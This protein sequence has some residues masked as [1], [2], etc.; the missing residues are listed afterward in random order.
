MACIWGHCQ[1]ARRSWLPFGNHPLPGDMNLIL[2]FPGAIPFSCPCAVILL[3]TE[4]GKGESMGVGGG[5]ERKRGRWKT[6]RLRGR[7]ALSTQISQ[8]QGS[9]WELGDQGMAHL[10]SV[11]PPVSSFKLH[12]PISKC[13][14]HS[15]EWKAFGLLRVLSWVSSLSPLLL[16][17]VCSCGRRRPERRVARFYS[18]AHW[19]GRQQQ[20]GRGIARK[21]CQRTLVLTAKFWTEKLERTWFQVKE[22]HFGKRQPCLGWSQRQII[23]F[24]SHNLPCQGEWVAKRWGTD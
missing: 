6:V 2:T 4:G 24:A 7:R 15:K 21:L 11:H 19:R 9:H 16:R 8:I 1:R 13:H 18:A 5:E 23:F 17:S 10:L 12:P 20:T 14:L 3:H 22:V